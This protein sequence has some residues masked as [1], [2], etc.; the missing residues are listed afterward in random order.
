MREA[1]I[2]PA[3]VRPEFLWLA[4]ERLEACEDRSAVTVFIDRGGVKENEEVLAHFPWAESYRRAN[5]GTYGN[6][7]NLLEAYRWA[8]ECG[9]E[10][11]FCVEEDVLVAP[12]FFRW[13]RAVQAAEPEL[14]ASIATRNLRQAIQVP[15]AP[16]GYYLAGYGF[17]STGCCLP[18]R[19]IQAALEHTPVYYRNMRAYCLERFPA[20]RF[21]D[22]WWEQDGLLLRIAEAGDA[23]I[24]WPCVPR[25][26]HVGY[27]GYNRTGQGPQGGLE[28]RV[29]EVR[30][31][32]TDSAAMAGGY[33]DT[34]AVPD[35][36]A[37]DWAALRRVEVR[38]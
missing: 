14:F 29:A 37:A 25:A 17:S 2:V 6:S 3:H 7:L 22:S 11:V 5:H 28:E 33:G 16:D 19:T 9:A 35:E 18:R 36:F 4:L 34:D 26:W 32:V 1:C 31:A 21:G 13:H 20:S 38:Q 12:D 8:I 23:R 10:Q 15:P 30:R 24:S 27:F